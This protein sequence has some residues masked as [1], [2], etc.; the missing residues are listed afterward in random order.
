M[1]I[2]ART[3]LKSMLGRSLN[4]FKTNSWHFDSQD[5]GKVG[6]GV[7]KLSSSS[8]LMLSGVGS[9]GKATEDL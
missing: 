5:A 9:A 3:N 6:F 4:V 1:S 8:C 7:R 2:I